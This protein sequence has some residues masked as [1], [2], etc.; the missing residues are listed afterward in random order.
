MLKQKSYWSNN[1]LCAFST[2]QAD[3]Q[4][5]TSILSSPLK[6]KWRMLWAFEWTELKSRIKP[7]AFNDDGG[8]QKY[9]ISA[10]V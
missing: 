5:L 7:I 9:G 10:T 8:I 6:E 4:M 1:D 2:D 3:G